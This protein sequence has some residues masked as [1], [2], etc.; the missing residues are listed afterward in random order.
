MLI[1]N[2]GN[3]TLNL[4]DSD[5]RLYTSDG[6]SWI[7]DPPT[8]G[9]GIISDSGKVYIKAQEQLENKVDNLI[10]TQDADIYKSPTTYVKKKKGTDDVL[11]TKTFTT[12]GQGNI[13][14]IE[15]T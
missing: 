3:C 15:T 6:S 12:D 7:K 2:T 9:F 13:T 1:D 14:L 8:G 10:D 11:V 5:F 4:T